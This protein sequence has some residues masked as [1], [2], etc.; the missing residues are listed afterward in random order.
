LRIK[1]IYRDCVNTP[2]MSVQT[3]DYIMFLS[4]GEELEKS[5]NSPVGIPS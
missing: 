2:F 4:L 3:I 5:L 1:A